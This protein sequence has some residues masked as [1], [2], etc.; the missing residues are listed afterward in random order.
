M[1]PAQAEGG[2][3]SSNNVKKWGPI[4]AIALVVALDGQVAPQPGE[5]RRDGRLVVLQQAGEGD[6]REMK[7]GDPGRQRAR[8]RVQ[9]GEL[10][11]F[12]GGD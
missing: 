7:A 1:Q 2:G 5:C 9:R 3:S 10:V 4:G 11:G 12:A 8:D 6:A